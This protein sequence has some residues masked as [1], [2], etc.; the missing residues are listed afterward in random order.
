MRLLFSAALAASLL[1]APAH[2]K[3]PDTWDG[4]YRVKS[5]SA[6][7]VYLLPGV[8]FG[9]YSKIMLDPTEVSFEKNWQ[10]D[11][12]MGSRRLSSA[13]MRKVLDEA[14]AKF[15]SN[16]AAVLAKHGYTIV[17]QPGDDVLRLRTGIANLSFV[18][19]N[20]MG[21]RSRTFSRESGGATLVVE[22][23]DSVTGALLGRALDTEAAGDDMVYRVDEQSIRADFERLFEDWAKSVASGLDRLKSS[24]AVDAGVKT[25]K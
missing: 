4:L 18:M 7:A 5:K 10:R 11:Q 9:T 1:A 24:P 15:G 2:A 21:G 20:D 8:N 22:G 25:Q 17:D 6:D 13:E 19:P 12:P 3:M 16:L 14:S 23:R